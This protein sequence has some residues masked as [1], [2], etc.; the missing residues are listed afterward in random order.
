MTQMHQAQF[1]GT[2]TCTRCGGRGTYGSIGTCFLCG[3]AGTIARYTKLTPEHLADT[4][5]AVEAERSEAD[6]AYQARRAARKALTAEL[7]ASGMAL[8]DARR[9][10]RRLLA[11]ADR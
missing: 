2:E 5:A 1:I 10:S 4:Q 9:E 11:N 3:G 7:V 6:A 8:A